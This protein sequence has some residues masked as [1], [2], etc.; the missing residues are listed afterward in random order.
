MHLRDKLIGFSLSIS[1]SLLGVIFVPCL[2]TLN[3][4]LRFSFLSY[5]FLFGP[6]KHNSRRRCHQR[7]SITQL[8][9]R[10][11]TNYWAFISEK[12]MVSWTPKSHVHE[13]WSFVTSSSNINGASL[14]LIEHNLKCTSPDSSNPGKTLIQRLPAAVDTSI[15]SQLCTSFP[16]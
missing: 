2:D 5:P 4:F 15:P 3:L 14:S 11:L 10:D 7:F 13:S 1:S 6:T 12:Q 16:N 8:M 9:T